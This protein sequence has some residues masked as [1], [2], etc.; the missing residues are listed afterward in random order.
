MLAE[1]DSVQYLVP[2][3]KFFKEF[4]GFDR[5]AYFCNKDTCVKLSVKI[6]GIVSPDE[7]AHIED[8]LAVLAEKQKNDEYAQIYNYVTAN[9][10]GSRQFSAD[11]FMEVTQAGSGDTIQKGDRVSVLYK[12]SFL[13][14]RAADASA[15]SRPFEF[16][17][18]QEGQV[19]DGLALALYHLKKGEKAKIILPSRL[20]FGSRGSSNGSIAPYTPLLYEVQIVDVKK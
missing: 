17:M 15:A 8:S 14:G 1:G 6:L 13:D 7:Y 10:K 9:F 20:A 5:A 4:F 11:A 16:T 19:I 18:G 2:T 3:V 12:G